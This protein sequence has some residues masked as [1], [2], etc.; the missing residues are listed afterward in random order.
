MQKLRVVVWGVGVQ[1]SMSARM[2]SEKE[3][4]EI[5]GAIDIDKEKVGRDLGDVANVGRKLGII[6]SDDPDAVLAKTKPDMVLHTTLSPHYEVEAQAMKC[7]EAGINVLTTCALRLAYPWVHYP[8]LG[9]KFDEA[10]KKNGV[11][12]VCA[13]IIPGLFDHLPI[14][15]SG[16][17][18][19]VRKISYKRVTDFTDLSATAQGRHGIGLAFDEYQKRLADGSI[20]W[21][22]PVPPPWLDMIA[23]ALG[24]KLDDTTQ[25]VEAIIAKKSKR[26]PSGIEIQP[27]MI[28][29][30]HY[31]FSCVKDGEAVIT[32][33]Y[34]MLVDPE[35][36]GLEEVDSFSIEGEPNNINAVLVGGIKGNFTYPT[37]VNR[38]PQVMEAK[39]GL[40]CAKDLPMIVCLK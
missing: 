22:L 36:E 21:F 12:I 3:W 27:G 34:V 17:C 4:I 15:L 2:M 25:E 7:I 40:V 24:W 23:D 38:I 31:R 37:L 16:L 18:S 5:V 32:F 10:A 39:P 19:H 14:I 33:T 11:T 26:L 8:E 28:C 9:R 13:G 35:G 6:V 30:S 20:G 29:G 1:G